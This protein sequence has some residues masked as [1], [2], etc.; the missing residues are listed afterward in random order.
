MLFDPIA[1]MLSRIRN[2]YMANNE[3][4]LIAESKINKELAKIMQKE[5]YLGKI[6]K[7][8]KMHKNKKTN[9][10]ELQIDLVYQQGKPVLTHISRLSKLGRRLYIKA[11]QIKPVLSG[12]GILIVSTPKGLMTG[13]KAK[14]ENIG[15]ELICQV[16]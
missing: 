10:S 9:F 8:P 6:T 15:G 3:S 13:K 16:W 11:K 14:K 5:G 7:V 12:R 2:A 4:V 1:D